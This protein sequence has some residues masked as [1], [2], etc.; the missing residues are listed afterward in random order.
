MKTPLALCALLVIISGAVH[1]ADQRHPLH[2]ALDYDTNALLVT[3]L[4]LD[5]RQAA[6]LAAAS[7]TA[8]ATAAN[9]DKA[10]EALLQS[11]AP[12]LMQEQQALANGTPLPEET[13]HA[14]AD[15]RDAEQQ[16]QA[17]LHATVDVQVR[18][19][20]RDLNPQQ[21]ALVNWTPPSSASGEDDA[22]LLE[23]LRTLAA[24]LNEAQR[25]ME[26]IRFLIPTDYIQTH[27]AR[28]NEFLRAYKRPGTPD[29]D[30]AA[31]W[32]R[33]LLNDA[34]MVKEEDWPQQG[35][36]LASRLLQYLGVLDQT[37]AS[38]RQAQTRY[39]WWDIYYLLT[40]DQTPG[41]IQT[42]LR[43]GGGNQPDAPAEQAQPNNDQG[44]NQQ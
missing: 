37:G 31:E 44:A 30:A 24:R 33:N 20:R 5:D 39:N 23:E 22:A 15:L 7:K 6:D 36:L 2:R 4:Q 35:P 14:L 34:R 13:A 32:T 17:K 42:L 16:R 12:L 27:V 26:R 1:A 29:F 40:D 19:F 18:R 43:G 28:I 25:F 11:K 3:D 41:M 8:L 10:H 9:S 38:A 21:A